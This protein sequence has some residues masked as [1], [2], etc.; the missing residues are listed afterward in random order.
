MASVFSA[1]PANGGGPS[2]HHQ[3]ATVPRCTSARPATEAALINAALAP[4]TRAFYS[5]VIDKLASVCG[6][7]KSN[8]FPVSSDHVADYI[9]F[10][11]ESGL[12]PSSMASHAS[13]IAYEH[14]IRG[15][16]DPS[17]DFYVRQL[18]AGAKKMRPSVD[19]RKPLSISEI[20]ELCETLY[21]LGLPLVERLAWKAIFLVGFFALLRPGELVRGQTGIHTLQL[22]YLQISG[23]QLSIRIPSSK[24]N[25][26]PV[27]IT[28]E[29]RPDLRHCPVQ[30]VSEYMRVRREG[31]CYFFTDSVGQ[32]FTTNKL[33]LMLK[34]AGSRLGWDVSDV[35][36]HCLRIGGATHGGL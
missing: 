20:F 9:V 7:Q 23:C 22:S 36:G 5:R 1:S 26:K 3:S 25:A 15:L 10:L 2:S 27:T 31:E 29:A 8:M 11:F 6:L 24:S 17:A 4:S 13:A 33:S 14:K 28:L 16:P 19:T 35:S 34:R 32:G 12:A 21:L 30:A 18:I